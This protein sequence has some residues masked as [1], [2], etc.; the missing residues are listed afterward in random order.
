MTEQPAERPRSRRD[1]YAEQTREAV[2]SAARTLFAERGY[3]A[4]TINDIAAASRVSA[5]TVYQQCGGKQGLLR[6]LMDMWTTSELVK[7][8]LVQVERA[9]SLADVAT[10]LSDS[11]L[12][13]WRRYDDIVQLVLATAVH[14]EAAA[15]SLGQ[16]TARHRG[17]LYEIARKVRT[18]GD[19][20]ASFTDEDFADITLYHYGPQN[21]Y[22]F[23]V[24]VLGWPEARARTFLST[25][26][27]HSLRDAATSQPLH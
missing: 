16:A 21:G 13:F 4:T 27:G 18:L 9:E 7:D 5:G 19:F 3:Y 24:T 11:Y 8:T 20:P 6:T 26:F 22:H 12:E 25:Q 23:T 15:E 14:D 10:V 17:A 1:E 2:V